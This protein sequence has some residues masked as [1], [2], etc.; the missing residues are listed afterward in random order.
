MSSQLKF[1]LFGN[2]SIGIPTSEEF[3]KISQYLPLLK[4]FEASLKTRV[5]EMWDFSTAFEELVKQDTMVWKSL[6]RIYVAPTETSFTRSGKICRRLWKFA[7]EKKFSKRYAK[8]LV[9]S[10]KRFIIQAY[11]PQFLSR[12]GRFAKT[13]SEFF[14][15][16]GRPQ[17]LAIL[18]ATQ[19]A[20]L[21]HI[22]KTR[23][24]F[25]AS[26]F[27]RGKY[28]RLSASQD[29]ERQEHLREALGA[30]QVAFPKK[31]EFEL[32][33][34]RRKEEKG[35][36]EGLKDI[37][38]RSVVPMYTH[39]NGP[40]SEQEQIFRLDARNNDLLSTIASFEKVI[41]E[42]NL[43]HN[44]ESDDYVE[45]EIFDFGD[46]PTPLRSWLRSQDGLKIHSAPITNRETLELAFS[47]LGKGRVSN[48]DQLS[49]EY[50]ARMVGTISIR[51]I[52][53]TQSGFKQGKAIPGEPGKSIHLRCR[54]CQ[55]PVLDDAFPFFVAELPNCYIIEVV[56]SAQ[57]GGNGCGQNGCKGKPGLVPANHA[58]QNHTRMET[59][60]ISQTKRRKANWKAPLCRTG[61]DLEG[62]AEIVRVRCRGSGQEW[63]IHSP[64]RL[65]QPRL[66]CDCDGKDKD[67]Y[68]EPVDKKIDMISL[69]NLRKIH[70]GFLNAHCDLAD[71]PKLPGIIFD[72]EP[73]GDP[74]KKPRTY[75]ERFEYLKNAKMALTGS[76]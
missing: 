43:F 3:D 74:K 50:L 23:L 18:M 55:R 30:F 29:L 48:L 53:R 11:H 25:F 70:Q 10:M 8:L 37:P 2:C 66:K 54:G 51:K 28:S 67:H 76:N 59:R 20:G 27:V 73:N 63:T 16:Y 75:R 56:R 62:C 17:D 45:S 32:R 40:I 42:M 34:A 9:C 26:H 46:I 6:G 49:T 60:A 68:F 22:I 47:L 72:L 41:K 65:V 21:Q 39:P 57:N 4:A 7:L 44:E 58:V 12:P 52:T 24:N 69:T 19:L 33:E 35:L 15:T 14:E 64:A 13:S 71:Y 31:F 5:K 38:S 61:K 1:P 36:L